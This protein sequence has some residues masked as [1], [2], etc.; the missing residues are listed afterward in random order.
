MA[1]PVHYSLYLQYGTGTYHIECL[2]WAR[3][4]LGRLYGLDSVCGHA[5]ILILG[6][7]RRLWRREVQHWLQISRGDDE[8]G[9][10]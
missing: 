4:S 7:A 8:D 2:L 3:F 5:S 6:K 1:V 9:G 10:T